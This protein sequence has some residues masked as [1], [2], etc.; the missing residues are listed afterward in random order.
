ML[1]LLLQTASKMSDWM[2]VKH[3]IGTGILHRGRQMHLAQA[4]ESGERD[5]L[6]LWMRSS[7]VRNIQ[8]PMCEQKP[9]LIPFQGF[10]DGFTKETTSYIAA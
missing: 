10:G 7:S 1:C 5:N 2:Q 6:I 3:V 4:V 9:H 8:C